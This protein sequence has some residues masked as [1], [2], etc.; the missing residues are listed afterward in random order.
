MKR[1]VIIDYDAGNLKSVQRAC[2][3]VGL[4]AEIVA[5]PAEV[6][7]RVRVRLRKERPAAQSASNCSLRWSR[8]ISSSAPK[9]SSISRRSASNA[10]ARP[11]PWDNRREVH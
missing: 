3:E 1:A 8:T 4:D 11:S 7:A 10:S 6:V 9:G 5:D 2:H